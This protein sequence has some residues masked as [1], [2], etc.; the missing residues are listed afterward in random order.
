M[1]AIF[2]SLKRDK[3]A[4]H[5]LPDS[6]FSEVYLSF[7]RKAELKIQ[8]Y[9]KNQFDFE[10]LQLGTAL[11][12]AGEQIAKVTPDFV[13]EKFNIMMNTLFDGSEGVQNLPRDP[14]T[15]TLDPA[16]Y[17]QMMAV[18]KLKSKPSSEYIYKDTSN[19]QDLVRLKKFSQDSSAI[20]VE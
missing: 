5:N 2:D 4:L 14:T 6:K 3:A 9:L 17:K 11:T 7:R 20:V 10:H 19:A 8:T 18:I 13:K 1:E 12:W 16:P 15:Y